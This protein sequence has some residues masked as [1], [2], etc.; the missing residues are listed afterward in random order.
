MKRALASSTEEGSAACVRSETRAMRTERSRLIFLVGRSRG[1][2][3]DEGFGE[4]GLGMLNTG[5]GQ[6]Q[7]RLRDDMRKEILIS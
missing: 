1:D 5:T 6:G 2:V 4:E 3:N 7:R